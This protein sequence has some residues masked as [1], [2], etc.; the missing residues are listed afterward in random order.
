MRAAAVVVAAFVVS[1]GVARAQPPLHSNP[2]TERA[3][4]HYRLGW[5]LLRVER[6][7]DAAKE[8]Q[9][10]IDTDNKFKLAYYGLGRSYMGLKRFPDAIK[11]YEACRGFYEADAGEKFRSVQEADR[12]RQTDL[13][14]LRIAIN[15]L[16][17]R[18]QGQQSAQTTQNQVRLLRDQ[19]QRIELKRNEINNNLSIGSSIP[20]FVSVALGSAYFRSTRLGDAERAYR[21]AIDIDPKAGE[22]WNNLAVVY[23]ETSRYEEADKAV[24]AAEKVGFHVHPQLK[25]DIAKRRRSISD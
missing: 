18:S 10:A 8:F 7:A 17:S 20:A 3:Q 25:E 16:S 21:A 1:S 23:L 12:M 24:K 2:E 14:Q 11:A 4:L 19:A 22:A 15:A 6:W 9:L 5:D 13:D